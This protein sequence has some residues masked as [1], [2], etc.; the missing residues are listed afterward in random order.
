MQAD[1]LHRDTPADH[2]IHGVVN[3]AHGAAPQFATDEIAPDLPGVAD[4]GIEEGIRCAARAQ[5]ALYFIG[6][7]RVA[8]ACSFDKSGPFGFRTFQRL[9]EYLTH[10][11]MEFRFH[12]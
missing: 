2:R 11:L 3:D 6:Q 7:S 12:G 9:V 4:R 5:Q 10:P 1:H 8:G